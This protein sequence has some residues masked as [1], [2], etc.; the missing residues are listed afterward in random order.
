MARNVPKVYGPDSPANASAC[1]YCSAELTAETRIFAQT[2][3]RDR[4]NGRL[5]LRIQR[6]AYCKGKP[7][8]ANHQM[9]LEG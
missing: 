2:I 6:L 5:G 9:S 8:A 1:S 7:C 3:R 4:I